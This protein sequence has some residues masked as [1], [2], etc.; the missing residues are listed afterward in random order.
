MQLIVLRVSPLI[1]A[2][3]QSDQQPSTAVPK[4]VTDAVSKLTN[5]P[6]GEDSCQTEWQTNPALAFAHPWYN[7]ITDRQRTILNHTEAVFN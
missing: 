7:A 3:A 6:L 5:R 4:W 1:Q 2:A